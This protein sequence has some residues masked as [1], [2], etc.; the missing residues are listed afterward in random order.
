M[1]S[2][3]KEVAD[4]HCARC[5]AAAADDDDRPSI[6][7]GENEREVSRQRELSVSEYV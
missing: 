2:Q 5:T 1:S 3:P 6:E 4:C 7:R